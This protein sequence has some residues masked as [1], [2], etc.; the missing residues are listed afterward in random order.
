MNQSDIVRNTIRHEIVDHKPSGDGC[1]N[2]DYWS[3]HDLNLAIADVDNFDLSA[4]L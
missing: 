1:Y 3:K 2:I 4:N